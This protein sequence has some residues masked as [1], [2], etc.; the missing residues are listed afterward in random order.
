MTVL[1]WM[2]KLGQSEKAVKV[3]WEPITLATLNETP[4]ITEADAFAKV[5]K[6]AFFS[7]RERSRI[8]IARTGLS[9][10]LCGAE[11]FLAARGG[12]ILL[13]QLVSKI[14]V[15]NGEATGVTLRDGTA[16]QADAVVAA[17]PFY[18]LKNLL[19]APILADPFFAGLGQLETS[20]IFSV[21]L[22]FDRPVMDTDFAGLL[23]TETHWVFNKSRILGYRREGAVACVIS[24]ARKF[25]ETPD[26]AL[27]KICLDEI[28][29]CLPLSRAAVFEHSLIVR[30]KNATL[31][32][33]VGYNR[34]RPAQKTPVK[35][36]MIAGD[37]TQTGLPATLES[38]V[39]SGR[40][41]AQELTSKM[42]MV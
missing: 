22:W 38:A 42:E 27:L 2:K 8:V 14:S 32:P 23:D 35:N 25:L 21:S 9:D 28:R 37:W 12:K 30:E 10:L 6:E 17:V 7:G 20:P 1:D 13:N 34:F 26:E 40:L 31:S 33:K 16:L 39:V 36:L 11:P 41:A 4:D 29:D 3:L 18:N 24:G 15:H 5:L 19:D